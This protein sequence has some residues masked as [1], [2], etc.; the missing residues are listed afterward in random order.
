MI[1]T[2]AWVEFLRDTGSGVCHAVEI[3]LEADIAVSDPIGMEVL[4]GARDEAHL[5][6]L[7][8]LLGRCTHIK[9]VPV[10]YDQAAILYRQ[11]RV[12]GETVRKLLAC[13]IAAIA[14]RSGRRLLHNDSDFVALSR[15]TRLLTVDEFRT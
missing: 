12:N 15:H 4:A 6:Q 2:S 1:D 5:D 8:R 14:I 13:L 7:R 3:A 11:C 9:A 10:D